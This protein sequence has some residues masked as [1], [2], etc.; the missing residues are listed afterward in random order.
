VLLQDSLA[1]N[2]V[3]DGSNAETSGCD[4]D[5]MVDPN[6]EMG[7]EYVSDSVSEFDHGSEG[8]KKAPGE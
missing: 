8:T 7:S 3:Y 6:I 5:C 4:G 1:P 2:K